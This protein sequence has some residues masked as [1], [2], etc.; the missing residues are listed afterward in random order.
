MIGNFKRE[1]ASE[2]MV[3]DPDYLWGQTTITVSPA[4]PTNEKGG[5]W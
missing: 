3:N 1:S 5:Q 2:A 4:C